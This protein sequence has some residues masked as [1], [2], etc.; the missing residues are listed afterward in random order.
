VTIAHQT[1]RICGAKEEARAI[2]AVRSD[3]DRRYLELIAPHIKGAV[4]EIGCG[5]GALLPPFGGIADALEGVELTRIAVER[6][7]RRFPG[8]KFHQGSASAIGKIGGIKDRRFDVII[9]CDVLDHLSDREKEALV[10]W[11]AKHLAPG[12]KALIAGW[13]PGG[14]YLT[15][16]ELALL[17]H[18]HLKEI[19]RVYCDRSEHLALVAEKRRRLVAITI[20]YETWQPIP[21]GKR[22][23]WV[24]DVF[25]PT[26][27]LLELFERSNVSAT[28]F[29]EMGEYF[30]LAKN[31]PAIALRME[32]QWREIV[33]REHDVQLHL[34]PSWLPET[35]ARCT[36]GE[37]SWD[38]SKAK[39]SEYPGDLTAL[40]DRCKAAIET[41]VRPVRPGY[42][43]TCYRA[44]AYQVQPFERLSRALIENDIE[45]D[46]SVNP[47]SRN[48]QRG[49]DY[50]HAYTR[51]QPYFGDLLD[52]QLKA[53]PAEEKLIELPIFAPE[54]GGRWFIDGDDSERLT[55]RLLSYEAGWRRPF[56]TVRLRVH[57][58]AQKLARTAYSSSA[59]P[60]R[61]INRL[62]PGALSYGLLAHDYS[63]PVAPSHL[64][65][66]AI[67]H[68]KAPLRFATLEREFARLRAELD[69]EFVTLSKMAR[70]AREDL[71]GRRRSTAVAEIAYQ[72]NRERGAVLSATSV[73]PQSFHLQD[74]IPFDV[75]RVLDVGCGS[76]RWS[77]RIARLYPWVSVVGVDAG[78]EFI[79][80][81]QREHAGPRVAFEVQDFCRLKYPEATFD[82]AYADNTLE[83]CFDLDATLRELYR[84]LRSGGWLV[85][86]VPPDGLNPDQDCDNHTWKTIAPQVKCRLERVGFL[87]IT[88]EEVN[89]FRD[90]GMSPFPPSK[91]RMIYVRARKLEATEDHWQ[92]ATRAVDWIYRRIAP[93]QPNLSEDPKQ[94][95]ADG[96][97][98]CI[99]YTLALGH[100]LKREG[101]DVTWI[102]M[103]AGGHARGHGPGQ[104]DSHEVI[105]IGIDGRRCVLDPMSNTAFP[106][107]LDELL[108][109]P[110]LADLPA[111]RD[112][113]C[114]ARGYHLY[115]TSYWYSRVTETSRRRNTRWPSVVWEKNR[116]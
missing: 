52:P 58:K 45:C 82:C 25:K 15:P 31:E 75:D 2:G 87:N 64:Y 66:V 49:Y 10:A 113:R 18:K 90:L 6:E 28:F 95:I 103:R 81:A 50:S 100:L 4:L 14:K 16:S 22:I 76:G 77:S 85:A 34:H 62:L 37:W 51:H 70:L 30:W 91:D 73:S 5:T 56:S 44:G 53:V 39:A 1:D 13:C 47:Q 67:G 26:E 65:Y 115:N 9:C 23:D 59:S 41:A 102:T 112:E 96:Y 46:S 8:I 98:F 11:I 101:Y 108:E 105:E 93:T 27:Q 57:D 86:A 80:K 19:G 97:G 35:G 106:Y 71:E 3:R 48:R 107:S 79:A 69:V 110:A 84:V 24:A 116:K 104:E 43:V 32:Q 29:L 74:M 40:I 99:A 7:A 60:R 55:D 88:I 12:G 54:P 20:D 17:T 72:V 94:I 89:T 21:E 111:N 42:I 61:L 63:R 109:D 68:T 78:V 38:W 114:A 83:H 36:N 33:G 92:R